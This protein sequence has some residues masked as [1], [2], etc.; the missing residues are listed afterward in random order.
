MSFAPPH[1]QTNLVMLFGCKLGKPTVIATALDL[2][3]LLNGLSRRNV[4]FTH[5]R[6]VDRCDLVSID[7]NTT[8]ISHMEE[9]TFREEQD[10]A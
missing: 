5:A 9:Q 7:H 4:Q 2:E 1:P 8:Y 10:N 6:L 3:T